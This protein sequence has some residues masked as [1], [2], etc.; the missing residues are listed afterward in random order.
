MESV[1]LSGLLVQPITE[2]VRAWI[3]A[4]K[5]DEND[6]DQALTRDARDLVDHASSAGGDWIPIADV[7]SLVALMAE[8][9]GGETGL[10]EW[11]DEIV[12]GWREESS[13]DGLLRAG[14][15]LVDAPG[16]IV[17]MASD[18][19]IRTANWRYEGSRTTFS[20]RVK[21]VGDASPVLKTLLG[22]VLARLAALARDRRF[23]VRFEGV[24][25]RN[26]VVF[27]EIESE[28]VDVDP[29]GESRL[30]RAALIA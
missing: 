17:S 13:I 21:G 27:G 5:L 11:A 2:Q 6:L 22:A 24:D 28:G 14:R 4:G 12:S 20:V 1:C 16:Y 15:S 10:V 7:E 26:L 8:Q 29:L 18:L 30:H 25:G 9:L 23:D 3:L 19:L